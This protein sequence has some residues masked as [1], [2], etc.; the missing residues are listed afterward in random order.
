M[1]QRLHDFLQ[2]FENLLVLH[3]LSPPVNIF[4]KHLLEERM[5][6]QLDGKV[7]GGVEHKLH[8]FRHLCAKFGCVHFCSPL[9]KI[10]VK[11]F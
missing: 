9:L 10:L 3:I 8:V 7:K 1:L 4:L 5:S 2:I 11:H 6:S